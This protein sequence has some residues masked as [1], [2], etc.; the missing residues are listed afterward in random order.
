MTIHSFQTQNSVMYLWE[1]SYDFLALEEIMIFDWTLH[2]RNSKG[3]WQS[4]LN[5]D[6]ARFINQTDRQHA[7]TLSSF[8]QRHS[9]VTIQWRVNALRLSVGN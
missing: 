1:K 2:Y 9:Y 5:W 4:S 3:I 8:K 6:G 7:T